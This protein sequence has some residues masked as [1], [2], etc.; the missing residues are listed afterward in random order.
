MSLN[1]S[2][3]ADRSNVS[4]SLSS[5]SSRRSNASR[6]SNSTRSHRSYS[7]RQSPTWSN[8]SYYRW[9]PIIVNAINETKNDKIDDELYNK[10]LIII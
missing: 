6:R 9:E 4:S 10:Y 7:S 5:I 1:S 8:S 3:S 2:N